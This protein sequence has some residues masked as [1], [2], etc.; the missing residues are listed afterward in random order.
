MRDG[1]SMVYVKSILAGLAAVIVSA[2]VLPIVALM[3]PTV[4]YR[5]GGYAGI[6]FDPSW[7]AHWHFAWV[8][9]AVIFGAAFYWEFQRLSKA[10]H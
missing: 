4:R 8:V 1:V 9:G 5:R 7:L 2:V 10:N 6:G 3:A